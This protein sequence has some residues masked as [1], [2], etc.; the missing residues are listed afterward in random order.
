[1][2]MNLEIKRKNISINIDDLVFETICKQAGGNEKIGYIFY[3]KIKDTNEYIINK[4]SPPH[5][6]DIS[7][8]GYCKISRKH[9]REVDAWLSW[10][11]HISTIGY[12]H[13]HPESYGTK[14]SR[15][16]LNAFWESSLENEIS[17]FIIAIKSKVSIYI[18][19]FGR[20]VKMK[21]WQI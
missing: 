17:I 7:K 4:I 12:Y 3:E 18:Y 6:K 8:P 21:K 2:I 14:R 11:E 13:T 9:K 20:E 1:M 16:D 5:K 10:N 15:V 19:S